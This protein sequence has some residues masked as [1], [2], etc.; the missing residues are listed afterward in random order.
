MESSGVEEDWDPDGAQEYTAK[1]TAVFG[2]SDTH[3]TTSVRG[4]VGH[5]A[6]EYVS[7]GKSSEKTDLYGHMSMLLELITGQ[8]AYDFQ[9]LAHDDDVMLLDWVG[10]S[11]RQSSAPVEDFG[12]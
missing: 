1:L 12:C 2:D 3:V 4:T 5:I 11:Y 9:R 6:P 7:T 10:I 8:R